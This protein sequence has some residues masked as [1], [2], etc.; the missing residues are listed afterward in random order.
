[1]ATSTEAPFFCTPQSLQSVCIYSCR[2]CQKQ[3]KGSSHTEGIPVSH[4]CGGSTVSMSARPSMHLSVVVWFSYNNANLTIP[5][6]NTILHLITFLFWSQA[7]SPSPG[8]PKTDTC[9]SE[10]R[11]SYIRTCDI[12]VLMYEGL[13]SSTLSVSAEC[14]LSGVLQTNQQHLLCCSCWFG[15]FLLVHFC[16][17]SWTKW[18]RSEVYHV[19]EKALKVLQ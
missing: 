14:L 10:C 16:F 5:H 9:D 7:A 6:N 4:C 1:M 18:P 12:H 17:G 3:Q 19:R 11:P 8:A 15:S 2:D 13:H